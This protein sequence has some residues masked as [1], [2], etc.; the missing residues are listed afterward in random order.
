MI[1]PKIFQRAAIVGTVLQVAMVV[2]GHFV[3][4]VAQH[5]FMFGG[6]AISALAGLLY[7]RETAAGYGPSALGGAAAGAVCALIGIAIS[8]LLHNT[9]PA[10]LA[11]GTASSA[12]T[13]AIGGLIG[14]ATRRN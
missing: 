3:P 6:M 10:I 4:W 13:G 11:I 14:Q 7:A 9:Q 1:N 5:V 2:I 12:V 8:V